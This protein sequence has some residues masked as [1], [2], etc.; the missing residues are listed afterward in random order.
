MTKLIYSSTKNS[1]MFYAVKYQI[2]D[3]FFYLETENK[4]YIFLDNREIEVFKERNKDKNLEVISI[5]KL[6]KK[7]LNIKDKTIF[8]NKLALMILKDF[9]LLTEKIEVPVDFPI[10]M[11]DYLRSYK[12]ELIPI[13]PFFPKRT[14]KTKSEIKFI[15]E[16]IKNTL[17]AFQRIEEILQE[18]KIKNDKILFQGNVLTSEFL[19]YEV[20]KIF[21]EKNLFNQEDIII[22]SGEQTAIPHHRGSGE[23]KPNSFIICD[24]FP[25][26]KEN[27][28]F[29][30]ITRTYV[31][32]KANKK[33]MA[34]FDAVK[35]AQ[36]KAIESIKPG[37]NAKKINEICEKYFEE[38]K[39][40]TVGNQG[41]IHSAGHSFGLDVHESPNL[42]RLSEEI[43]EVG[44][45][46]TVEPGLYF[47]GLGG[48]RIEDDVLVT[49]DGYENLVNW[50]KSLIV[51]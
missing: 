11:A 3:P 19:K 24:I 27:G 51:K 46:I 31:K 5:E 28:Y 14:V 37:I 35:N 2:S 49:K 12:V 40:K 43:L 21:L 42:S 23:I 13:K 22:S 17:V 50:N 4:K 32:G 38:N 10:F 15:K 18:S 45:V 44:N 8:A 1:N 26:S 29:A 47:P 16:N 33:M 34:I 36:E 20:E 41:F 7:A 48:V 25:R 9:K 39:F 6:F 30:D